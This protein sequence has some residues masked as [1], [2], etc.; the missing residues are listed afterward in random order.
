MKQLLPIISISLLVLPGITVTADAQVKTDTNIVVIPPKKKTPAIHYPV[1]NG[2][3]TIFSHQVTAAIGTVHDGSVEN[4][5]VP[6]V[7]VALQGKVAGLHAV[8]ANGMPVS[9]VALRLRGTSSI[10]SET[11]PLFV[12]DG[13]PVYAGPRDY[14][15]SGIGGTWGSTFNPL[16][17]I[18]PMDIQSI[19][20]LKDAAATAIYGSRGANGVIVITTKA[21]TVNKS[22]VHVDYY[23]GITDITNRRN[24][25]N[26]PGYL[27]VLD[28]SWHN[29]GSTGEGPLPAIPGLT[30]ELAAATSTDNPGE[31]L[32]QGRVQ[33]LSVSSSY[34]TARSS[35][36]FSGGFRKEKGVLTGNDYTRYT[37]KVKMTNQLTKRLTIGATFGINFTDYFNMP[38]GYSPGGGFNAAQLNLPVLP[39]YNADGSYFYPSDPAVYNLPGTNVRSF[40]NKNDFDNEEHTRRLAIAASL[41]YQLLPGLDL[42]FDAAMDQFQHTRRDYLSRHL[43]YGSLGSGAGREG[44]P[45]AYAGYEKNTKNVINLLTTVNY[46]RIKD[47][48]Q[49]TVVAGTEFYYSDNPYF[50]AEGEGFVSDFLRQPAA[51]A[52]RNQITPEGLTTNVNAV[53]G[54]FANGN[55]VYRERYLLNATVRVDGGSRFGADNKYQVYPAVSAGYLLFDD[56]IAASHTPINYLKVRMGY[57]WS[58]NYGIG[59]YANLERWGLGS[60]SRYMLQAGVQALA[61]GSPSLKPERVEEINAGVDFSLLQNRISGAIDV[62]NRVTHDLVLRF[63]GPLSLGVIDPGLLLNAG[64]MRNRGIELSVTT[65]NL[66]GKFSWS[67]D[68]TLAHN[69]NKVLDLAALDPTQ[70]SAHPN[71]ANFVGEATGTYYLARYAGVDPST[72]QELI[73]DRE[74]KIVPATSAA[75]IDN[76]RVPIHDKTAA[77]KIFGG[78]NNT[79]TWKGFDLSVF[80]TFSYR[81]YVLDE[82][83]RALSYVEGKNNLLEAAANSWTPENTS[84][85]FPR[86]LYK[87]PIAGSNTT[88]FLHDA[89]Y[90]RMKNITLGYSLKKVIKK[91]KF[92][93][94][95]RVYVTAQNLFTITSFPGWDPEVSGHFV[96]GIERSQH[97]GI[98]YMD[99]PQVKS[100]VAGIHVK[101]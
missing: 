42:R 24:V 17:D 4:L 37:G 29:S 85:A 18:N 46:K 86:L 60:T 9:E 28:Q 68:V 72:G 59:N 58:G 97:L 22:E 21:A 50:F 16:N 96:T 62:Y 11:D 43:R 45:L 99:V 34:G 73:Y 79:F 81:N 8:Q 13:V 98:T 63:P 26:G 15:A 48:H 61:L 40:L 41:G 2:Y 89:S 57:G 90:L 27:Q 88:R 55:Y 12:I 3:Q 94:D 76:A 39:L 31:L 101:L 54:F 35:F 36:Y 83:E 49:L 53:L 51:A 80:C 5:V 69:K 10:Y 33:Q 77:P 38:V 56:R 66:T 64:R 65:R 47:R 78:V 52:Y 100:F 91:I 87:D 20:V 67:T 75:Q 70:V 1:H 82:G 19:D 32:Q 7:K 44:A 95:V 30:R 74:G 23:N 84:T 71:V 92:L 25:L 93:K 6:N 14:P